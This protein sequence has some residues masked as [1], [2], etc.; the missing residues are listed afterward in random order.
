[1]ESFATEA[2]SYLCAVTDE[3]ISYQSALLQM[4][5]EIVTILDLQIVGLS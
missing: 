5:S 1:M 2:Q 3:I 4:L